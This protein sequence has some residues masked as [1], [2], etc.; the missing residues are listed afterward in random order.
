MTPQQVYDDAEDRLLR[1][2]RDGVDDKTLA[3]LR[4]ERDRAWR[5]YI[6][7]HAGRDYGRG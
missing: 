4:I 1:W 7:A 5:R 3:A 2:T 6:E